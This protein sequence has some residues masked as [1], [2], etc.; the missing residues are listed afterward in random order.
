MPRLGGRRNAAYIEGLTRHR[1]IATTI[2]MAAVLT[3]ASRFTSAFI[4]AAETAVA[5]A[6]T[7]APVTA[8]V[9]SAIALAPPPGFIVEPIGGEWDGVVGAAF[10]EDGRAIAWERTGTLWMIDADGTRAASPMLDISDEV[11]VFVDLGMLGVAVDPSFLVNGR[12]YQLYVVDRHH[13][14]FAGTPQYDPQTSVVNE[15]TIGRITRYTATASSNFTEIDATSR[16][17][18]VG[19]SMSTGIPVIDQSH[20]VGSLVFGEDGTL[21]VSVGDNASFWELDEGGPTTLGHVQQ[22]LA[23]GILSAKEDVGA[24]RAQLIDSLCG[25]IL[26]LDPAT[27]DGVPSNPFFD[28]RAARSRVWCLGLRNPFRMEIVPETGEHDPALA[29]PGTLVVGDVGWSDREEL[30]IADG[31]GLN[32][33]WPLFEGLGW[34]AYYATSTTHVANAD[35][36]NPLFGES[37]APCS[38]ADFAFRDLLIDDTLDA[39]PLFVNPCA[40]LQAESAVFS[41]AIVT[42]MHADFTGTGYVQFQNASDDFI[43]WTVPAAETGA[44]TLHF[45]YANGS[46]D[47]R[48]L[49]I[50]IDG[51]EVSSAFSCP[52]T[53]SW[54]HAAWVT[55]N[56]TLTVGDHL[57][58]ATAIGH[59][60][61]NIDALSITVAGQTPT[62]V[63]SSISRFVHRRP[64]IDWLHSEPVARVPGFDDGRAVANLVGS[65]ESGASGEPFQGSCAIG[66]A[67]VG[68]GPWPL[69]WHGVKLFGD[70]SAQFIRGVRITD[71]GNV[72]EVMV[73]DP[74]AGPVVFLHFNQQDDSLWVVRW[75]NQLVRIRYAPNTN[76][77]PVISLKALPQYGAAPLLIKFDASLSFDPEGTPLTF[78]WTFPD[79]SR[80]VTSARVEHTFTS[81]GPARHDVLLTVRDGD[82]V[83]SSQIIPVWTNNTPPFVQI[84]SVQ[85]GD[86]Y[87][88]ERETTLPLTATII[89]HEQRDLTCE[90]R[91]ILHHN[92]HT[93]AG[94]ADTSCSTTTLISPLGCGEVTYFYEVTLTVT[95]PLG[96]AAHEALSLYPDCYGKLVCIADMNDDGVV[97]GV[98]IAIVLSQWGLAGAGLLADIDGDGV[99]N[100]MDFAIVLG[101]WGPCP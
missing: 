40:L 22:A 62:A 12:I 43:E 91:T 89:D 24:Y 95:D 73:F 47:D 2:G 17:I 19:E 69:P 46:V 25:K 26:R 97:D 94:P 93:H 58:R 84:T 6:S 44:F 64:V 14:L 42:S 36:P 65:P 54:D 101:S 29:K 1:A 67:E 51:D 90:W 61:A 79:G 52:T 31:P 3:L 32:F 55:L 23:D 28:A 87:S 92:T 38:S 37:V 39:N 15:A 98:E 85:D 71:E 16:T 76:A 13:L 66:G 57:V 100:G 4:A 96:L 82:G 80:P 83:E 27:G 81:I 53:G 20:S 63:P 33:G 60:G 34:T 18:L 78:T 74:L 45:R 21:L 56:A 70:Y 10:I 41:G 68:P 8:L 9:S 35:A 50:T 72:K 49:R 75:G 59:G 48:P 5:S 86:L 7:A 99:V 88:M 11:G 77:A 30:N